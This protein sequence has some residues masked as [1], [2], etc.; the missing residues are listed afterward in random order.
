[1]GGRREGVPR[2]CILAG[3]TNNTKYLRD[4]TDAK[5]FWP[6]YVGEIDIDAFHRIAPQLW[7]EAA[8]REACEPITLEE[9]LYPAVTEIAGKSLR[10]MS[11][12]P[13][14]NPVGSAPRQITSRS[15]RPYG[16]TTRQSLDKRG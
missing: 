14:A 15:V 2:Q 4:V 7:A 12:S 10:L 3:T 5:R 9:A 1:M 13:L 16:R 8:H 6:V 11:G